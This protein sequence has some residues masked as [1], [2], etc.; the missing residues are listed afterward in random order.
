MHAVGRYPEERP[1]FQGERGAQR[2]KIFHPFVGF[3]AAVGEQPVI[4]HA[5]T[6]GTGH[7][8]QYDCR[9]QCAP[10][11]SKQRHNRSEVKH[12]HEK[13]SEPADWLFK[14]PVI[15]QNTHIGSLLV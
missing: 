6:H 15:L 13:H 7:K 8:E 11:E 3:V 2:K 1:A 9:N 10:T 14:S 5:N 12:H 4:S